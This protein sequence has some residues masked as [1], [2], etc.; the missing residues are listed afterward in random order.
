MLCADAVPRKISSL[1]LTEDLKTLMSVNHEAV[2]VCL[3]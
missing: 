1:V 3:S 2:K